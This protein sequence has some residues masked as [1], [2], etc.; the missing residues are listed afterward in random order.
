MATTASR[1]VRILLAMQDGFLAKS[2]KSVLPLIGNE[3]SHVYVESQAEADLVIF[4]DVREIEQGYSKEKSYAYLK[5]TSQPGGPRLPDNCTVINTMSILV[6]LVG[7]ITSA[8]QKLTPIVEAAPAPK[9]DAA[10]LRPDALRIL[11]I[12]D[13]SENISSAKKYLAGHQLTTV[14]GYEDAMNVLSKESFDVVLTDLHLPMSS[15]TMG[16]KFVLGQLVPY[17]L[18]LMVEA[19]RQGAKH[20][21]VVTDLSHHDDPFSAA[22]DHFSGCPVKIN[23]ANV[24]MMH[25]PMKNGAKDWAEALARLMSS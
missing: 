11:V 25:S 12:D 9:G 1:P 13:T 2:I 23:Q 18:L 22:F 7:V 6:D 4:T 15:K 14:S 8:G 19:A 17:G 10:P 16:D 5:T 21:A 3:S 20:V 24:V